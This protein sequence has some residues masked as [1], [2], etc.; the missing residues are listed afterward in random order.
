V[1]T[2][3]YLRVSTNEQT[4]EPQRRELAE[5]AARRG[6]QDLEEFSDTIS[7]AKF[8]RAGLDRLMADVRRGRIARVIVVKL[9]RLGRSLSH[10]AQILGELDAHRVALIAPSQGID[11]S[12]S[13]PVGRLQLNILGAIAEFERSLIRERTRAGLNA[14]RAR[15]AK[16]GRRPM[17]LTAEQRDAVALWRETPTSIRDLAN[18]LGVSVGKAHGIVKAA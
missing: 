16:L 8:T 9:D 18:R 2:A 13:N 4:N 3:L 6:W 17:R 12:S 14:A 7:G 15:G 10:L 11:T 1:K 5:F